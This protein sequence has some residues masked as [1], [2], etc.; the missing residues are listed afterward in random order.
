MCLDRHKSAPVPRKRRN[1]IGLR[2]LQRL[3]CCAPCQGTYLGCTATPCIHLHLTQR[4]SRDLISA[5]LELARNI[6]L[7]FLSQD[8]IDRAGR[9]CTVELSLDC[10]SDVGCRGGLIS[11]RETVLQASPP[12]QR[13]DHLTDGLLDG[14]AGVCQAT[15]KFDNG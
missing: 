3:P 4:A 12:P 7:D 13:I 1:F 2:Q 10:P 14:A 5:S 15:R 9:R 11:G 6:V 8:R